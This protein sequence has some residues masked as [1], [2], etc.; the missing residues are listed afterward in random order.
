M[1]KWKF[2]KFNE[3]AILWSLD[4]YEW[5]MDLKLLDC[6]LKNDLDLIERIKND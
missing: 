3:Y 5:F 6:E 2:N 4:F 1:I